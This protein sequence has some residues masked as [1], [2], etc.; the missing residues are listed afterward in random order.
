MGGSIP[1]IG[2]RNRPV[3]Y[4]QH[5]TVK[6][7]AKLAGCLA[8]TA[9]ARLRLGWS[10][11]EVVRGERFV[12]VRRPRPKTGPKPNS[13]STLAKKHG[14]LRETLGK[15]LRAGMP[16]D[17]ALATPVRPCDT[18]PLDGRRF[19]HLVVGAETRKG[20][21]GKLFYGATCDCG[22][23]RFVIRTLL[24][25]GDA[26]TCLHHACPHFRA[27][28]AERAKTFRPRALRRSMVGK[29][30]GR[31]QVT[32]HVAKGW[33]L[34]DC[35]CG[36]L[37]FKVH[38]DT[39]NRIET[40]SC[41][42]AGVWVP[43]IG[44]VVGKMRVIAIIGTGKDRTVRVACGAC[45]KDVDVDR[46]VLA[47][48][49]MLIRLGR[50]VGSCGCAAVRPRYE[51]KGEMKY[52]AEIAS[53]EHVPTQGL[54]RHLKRGLA[55]DEAIKAARHHAARRAAQQPHFLHGVQLTVAQ[56]ATIGGVD[57]GTMGFRLRAGWT[58]EEALS[59]VRGG[60]RVE[61]VSARRNDGSSSKATTP[62]RRPKENHESNQTGL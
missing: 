34:A 40:P 28:R 59:G 27:L 49:R 45:K 15:R 53:A 39:L 22:R 36:T 16:L 23:T 58:V 31:L 32:A 41:G 43:E 56:L 30:I 48:R 11:E 26:T 12:A 25:S 51:Y 37:A 29:H 19:G 57:A 38:R 33:Y 60:E 6:E 46:L 5:V 8:P 2:T 3:L 50:E 7:L 44:E 4:G 9:S 55:M 10:P 42:C 14:I 1:A 61:R 35:D 47:R 21:R 52:L 20:K 18:G 24:L 17:E 13:M 54:N 62:R